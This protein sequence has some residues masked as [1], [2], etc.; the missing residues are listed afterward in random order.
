MEPISEKQLKIIKI[1]S[2]LF[3]LQIEMATLKK[4]LDDKLQELNIQLKESLQQKD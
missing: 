1:K 4:R 3:D 2:D